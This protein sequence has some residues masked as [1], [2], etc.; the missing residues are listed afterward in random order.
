M[1]KNGAAD[2]PRGERWRGRLRRRVSA[3]AGSLW[4]RGEARNAT[5]SDARRPNRNT[6]RRRLD[7]QPEPD[8]ESS[9]IGQSLDSER[10]HVVLWRSFPDF[11]KTE[12]APKDFLRAQSVSGNLSLVLEEF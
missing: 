7:D 8:D 2:L 9:R 1:A 4:R 12:S 3:R 11:R 5:L 6:A 10:Y